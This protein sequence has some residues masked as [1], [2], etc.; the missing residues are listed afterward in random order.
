VTA[1]RPREFDAE[2]ALERALE[3]FWRNGYE[4]TSLHDLTRTMGIT[5]PSLYAAFGNKEELFR[6]V[7]ERYEPKGGAWRARA[8]R[9]PTAH[10][11]MRELLEG[12]ADHFGDRSHPPGC[13]A[14]HSALV[15]GKEAE[16]IRRTLATHRMWGVNGLLSRLKRA[17]AEGDLAADSNPAD[18][19]HFLTAVI[20]GIT[21]LAMDGVGRKELRGVAKLALKQLSNAGRN[22]RRGQKSPTG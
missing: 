12:A 2:Q 20:Y 16:P 13:L 22:S 7:L 10:A 1:G 8:L 14:M 19:A 15:C 17:K 4:G 6:T 18:L 21:V 9:A 11:F 5:R 3:L